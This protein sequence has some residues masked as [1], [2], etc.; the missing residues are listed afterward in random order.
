MIDP[1]EPLTLK[2]FITEKEEHHFV[3]KYKSL[4]NDS[5]LRVRKNQRL[6]HNI[7]QQ[8]LFLKTSINGT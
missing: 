1:P 8:I 4:K 3:E 7:I 6:K 2:I 5:H